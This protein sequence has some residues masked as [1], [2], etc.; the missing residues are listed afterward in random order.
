VDQHRAMVLELGYN[1]LVQGVELPRIHHENQS[2]CDRRY[3]PAHG[4]AEPAT[5]RALSVARRAH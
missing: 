3:V 4:L 5:G 2:T 1:R